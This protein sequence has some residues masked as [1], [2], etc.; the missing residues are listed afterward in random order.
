MNYLVTGGAGFI[1][2]HL[3]RRLLEEENQVF[4]VDDF[5]TGVMRNI[6]EGAVFIPIHMLYTLI[7]E[8][9]DG[10]Y[11]LGM[12]SS[13]P[14]YKQCHSL[15]GDTVNWSLRVMDLCVKTDARLVYASTSS[16]YNGKPTPMHE[17]LSIIPTDYYTEARL[18]VERLAELYYKLHRVENIGLRLFSVYGPGEEHKGQYANLVSQFIWSIQRGE[19]PVIYGGGGQTRDF[20]Y[21]DDVVEAFTLAMKSNVEHS[22]LNVGTGVSHSLNETVDTINNILDT[23]TPPLH[24]PNP[25][26]NY[27][28]DTRADTTRLQKTLDYTPQTTLQQGIQKLINTTKGE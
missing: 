22:I 7:D 16:L 8:G 20:T 10:V 18:T 25:I 26:K 3:A 17:D 9:L 15:V 23:N 5:S 4:I 28:Q 13:S 21:V 6:P 2:S 24:I 27:V 19:H 14:M 1:G 12:A 11:H